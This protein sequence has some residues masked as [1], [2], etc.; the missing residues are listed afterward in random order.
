MSNP[1]VDPSDLSTYLNDPSILADSV[2]TA[3]AASFIADAQILCESIIS[4]LPPAASVVVKRVAARGYVTVT[5]PRQQQLN[6]AGAP[7]GATGTGMGGVWLSR[8]DKADLRR[9]GGGGGAFTIDVLPPGVSEV[10]SLAVNAS[11]GAYAL[12]MAGSSA[13]VPFDATASAIEALLI[14]LP[15]IGA[16]N[17][18]V[19]GASGAFIITFT[20]ALANQPVPLMTADGT[21]LTGTVYIV[22]TVAGVRPAASGLPWWDQNI[23]YPNW[24]SF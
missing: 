15:T 20:G 14:A 16:G 17:V 8:A 12:A 4:P 22:E 6:A 19:T 9:L 21:G 18:A 2:A 5:S 1:I 13:T 23:S 7:F 3:R 10:Q 24:S 11:A